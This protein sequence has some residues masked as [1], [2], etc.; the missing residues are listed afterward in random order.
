MSWEISPF[1]GVGPIKFGMTRSEVRQVLLEEPR[2]I[3]KE[4]GQP[5]VEQYGAAGVQAYYDSSDRLEFLE[6]T[7][8]AE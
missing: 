3:P 4:P 1:V 2:M 8:E 7:P 5:L 6:V